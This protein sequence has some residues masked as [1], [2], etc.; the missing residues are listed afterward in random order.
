[1]RSDGLEREVPV[2]S[3][4]GTARDQGSLLPPCIED[5]VEPDALVR[6]VDAFVASL[7]L[8]ELGFGRTVAAATE[9]S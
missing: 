9:N 8:A 1:M 5:H 7:D 6:V 2:G 4:Q 3:I